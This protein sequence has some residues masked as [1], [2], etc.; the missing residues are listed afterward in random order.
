MYIFTDQI[1]FIQNYIR[2]CISTDNFSNLHIV[3]CM[4]QTSMSRNPP[5]A[6]IGLEE[7]R[8]ATAD[9]PV[10]SLARNPSRPSLQ[11]KSSLPPPSRIARSLAIAHSGSRYITL[12]IECRG[13]GELLTS[14]W[15]PVVRCPR[16]NDRPQQSRSRQ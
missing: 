6:R 2:R 11:K 5:H 13:A 1:I 10:C 14:R 12:H 8:E 9:V 15:R 7:L 4:F 3:A 16:R